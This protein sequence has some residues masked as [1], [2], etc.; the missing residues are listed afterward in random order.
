LLVQ[1]F[2]AIP[3]PVFTKTAWESCGGMDQALWYTADWDL[4]LKLASYGPV[5]YHEEVTTGFRI[6]AGSLTVMGS[7]NL[8]DFTSQME[9]VL[10]RHLPL[11]G[12]NSRAVERAAR[13]SIAVNT[14]LAS[15]SAGSPRFLW[16]AASEVLSLGP[17]GLQRYLRDSRLVER[18]APRVRAK[19]K[20]AF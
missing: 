1:N 19:L 5:I 4:W 8:D 16:R 3:T 12:E 6:H 11:I 10:N 15:A 13:A 18:V 17:Y 14:A 20:G 7:R 9:T 2:V